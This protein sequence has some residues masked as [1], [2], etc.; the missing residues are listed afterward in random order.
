MKQKLFFA[1]MPN[2][3]D[4]CAMAETLRK[5]NLEMSGTVQPPEKWHLTVAY[6]GWV[7]QHLVGDFVE[8]G[9]LISSQSFPVTL[10][11]LE[12]WPDA[13]VTVLTPSSIPTQFTRLFESLWQ[14][15]NNL[16]FKHQFPQFDPH[17]TLTRGQTVLSDKKLVEAIK[18]KI[19]EFMLVNS[20][21]SDAGAHYS[22]IQ[23]WSLI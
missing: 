16:G 15:L 20:I 6:L 19:D 7:E 23:R 5:S 13:K 10:G 2:Q 1:L 8:V 11:N 21:K 17:V 3:Q 22:I 12:Y 18:W 14:P 9:K 4:V